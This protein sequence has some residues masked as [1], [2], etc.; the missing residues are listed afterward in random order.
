MGPASTIDDGEPVY[1]TSLLKN[2]T[3]KMHAALSCDNTEE[4]VAL[5]S[6]NGTISCDG[7]VPPLL[8]TKTSLDK[9]RE[10]ITREGKH[11]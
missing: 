7:M 3:D 5:P 2:Y 8:K 6:E 1:C 4:E 11:Y 10:T 9:E